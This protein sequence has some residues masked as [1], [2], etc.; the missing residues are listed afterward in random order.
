[1]VAEPGYGEFAGSRRLSAEELG[2][3]QQWI[4][5]GASEGDT[6]DLPTAPVWAESW[7]LGTPDLIVTMPQ[8]YTLPPEG[9][10]V[11]RNFV[12]PIPLPGR[13]FVRAVQMR[14]GNARIVHHAFMYLDRTR[15]S[16][17]L[18]SKE[19]EPGF[20]RMETPE[21]ARMPS[22]QIL[23]YQPGKFPSFAPR[24]LAWVLE[25]DTDLV[26]QVHLNPT[27]K[28]ELLQA[29]LGF[30]FTEEPPTNT[31]FKVLLTSGS[32]T[33]R[34]EKKLQGERLVYVAGGSID[35]WSYRMPI[36]WRVRC[37]G[38][39]RSLTALSNRCYG[40]DW[41]FKWQGDYQYARGLAST[42]HRAAHGLHATTQPTTFEIRT[43]LPSRSAM[44]RNPSMRWL[45]YR[46][47]CSFRK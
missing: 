36:I 24:G 12:L 42:R 46:F 5:E 47:N 13:R 4:A 31:P 14:P 22:G 23:T 17:R 18:A 7:F 11:Y 43:T 21:S 40:S 8:A 41:D 25:K 34:Q 27:G 30:Y 6:S 26:L 29:S 19:S 39:P 2:L 38:M 44:A 37:V 16:R 33:F 35:H 3:L 9:R 1:M 28:P 15:Q 45:N 10:D 20:P 32:S